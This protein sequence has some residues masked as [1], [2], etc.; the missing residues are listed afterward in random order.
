MRRVPRVVRPPVALVVLSLEPWR[1]GRETAGPG[2]LVTVA[3]SGRL[4][5]DAAFAGEGVI[6]IVPL[7][8]EFFSF[9]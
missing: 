6:R 9:E 4:L 3:V 2:N 7:K 5:D 8:A 1:A